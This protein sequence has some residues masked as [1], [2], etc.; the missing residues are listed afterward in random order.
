MLRTCG[1]QS[2]TSYY[3]DAIDMNVRS[4]E[5]INYF[6]Y[7]Y[8][9]LLYREF[10]CEELYAYIE[11]GLGRK[12][13]ADGLR[14]LE[15][16]GALLQD[17]AMYVLKNSGYYSENELSHISNLI[18]N[19]DSLSRSE[20]LAAEGARLFKEGRYAGALRIY[21]SILKNEEKTE[22]AGKA[23]L[24]EVAFSAGIIYARLFMC[25]AANAM[26]AKAYELYP[27]ST[28]AKAGIYLATALGDDEELLRAIIRYKVDD[29]MIDAIRKRVNGMK[30]EIEKEKET[31][32]FCAKIADPAVREDIIDEWK[33]EYYQMMK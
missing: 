7:N 6:I 30:S 12:D 26:F 8:L 16:Q 28:Y 9:N 13:I 11:E 2:T 5:E 10:F 31:A 1:K 19:L 17:M 22:T 24:A 25:G 18:L 21:K 33:Q 4:L 23:F 14:E 29:D 3:I 32:E 27:D 15:G 20:R